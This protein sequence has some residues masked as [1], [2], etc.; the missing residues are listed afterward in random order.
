[1]KKLIAVFLFINLYV[2]T[3]FAQPDTLWTKTF[4]GLEHDYGYSVQQTSEGGYIIAGYT[5]SYGAGGDNVYL[6]KTE[7]EG[8]EQWSQ[9][10][11]GNSY[12][13][14][15]S[16]QQTSDGGYIVAGY[17]YSYGAGYYDVYLIKTDARGNQ[18]W[19]QT[20]GGSDWDYGYSVQQT[21]DG[22]YIIA[23]WTSSYGAGYGDVYLIKTDAGGNQQWYQTFGGNGW[24][25]SYS[26]Q[27]TSDGGYIIA[28][29]TYTYGAG[30]GDVYLIKTDTE[31]FQQWSRTFGGGFDDW[32][33]SVQQTSEGGYIIAGWTISFGVG[34][35]DVYLIKTNAEGFEQ[36]SQT[37]GG[38]DWDHSFNVQQ[39]SDGG[40]IIAGT[41]YT[42]GAGE[43]DV[44]LIKTNAEGFE[45]W[46]QTFGGGYY[47]S[48]YSV[49]QTDDGGY[50]ITGYTESYGAGSADV[51]LLRLEA[52]VNIDINVTLTPQNPPIQIPA[53]GGS[54]FYDI[55]MEN[56]SEN[57]VSF[58]GWTE[59][60]LPDSSIHRPII[61]REDL[62]LLPG[63]IITF[64]DIL[65]FVPAGAPS[66]DYLYRVEI[67]YYPNIIID[68]DSF[69]FEKLPGYDT[70][71]H[72][73][74]WM[75]YGWDEE[76]PPAI[77]T[78]SG[79]TLHN[80]YPNPFNPST[81][82]SF[83]LGA[84]SFVELIVYDIQGREV[85]RLAEGY[86]SPGEYDFVFDGSSLSSGIYFARFQAGNF[87]QVQK[88]LLVK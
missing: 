62:S 3:A 44:Y 72:N 31:G 74:G 67:G 1:M 87:H 41:T 75:L 24:D 40:Y 27:Q 63:E 16:V 42:Y 47:D 8:Y 52:E 18:Q 57:T 48:G 29:T 53:G 77:T 68:E 5:S 59:V 21:G 35:Y 73:L 38:I 19:Y 26:V 51:W 22:G 37:Y 14:S 78:P 6:I 43:G 10:F 4:G 81:V 13:Y 33:Y 7:A 11:G 20:Y 15:E 30:E 82:I 65:Q 61:L 64:E 84:A 76:K 25:Y 49:Q 69:Y 9:T 56:A 79:L 55:V 28:G 58:H 32:G 34:N 71:T 60:I 17:T 83:E 66:G 86:Y 54:F 39:T 88:M 23:G 46:S 50:I 80:A 85:A 2:F 45:Q 70:P 36:W 12:D